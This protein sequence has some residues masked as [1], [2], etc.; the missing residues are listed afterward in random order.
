MTCPFHPTA[1]CTFLAD[2]KSLLGGTADLSA[3]VRIKMH[4][5][6]FDTPV[7]YKVERDTETTGWGN[8]TVP[9]GCEVRVYKVS[10]G[11]FVPIGLGPYPNHR[12][13]VWCPTHGWVTMDDDQYREMAQHC[14]GTA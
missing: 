2:V 13:C 10:D 1:P 7:L 14:G 3:R 12:T 5:A 4:L 9:C 11:R 8:Y 6:E